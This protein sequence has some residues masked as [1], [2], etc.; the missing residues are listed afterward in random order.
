MERKTKEVELFGKKVSLFERN[1]GDVISLSKYTTE[2]DAKSLEFVV[3]VNTK[4]VEASL[5]LNYTELPWYKFHTRIKLQALLTL[6]NLLKL[7]Q[8]QIFS[9]AEQVL[10]LEGL[11]VKTEKKTQEQ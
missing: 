3:F 2:S 5:K 9:L 8:S 10:D 6:R 1:A 4:I 11:L 7:P